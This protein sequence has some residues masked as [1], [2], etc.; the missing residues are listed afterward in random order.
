MGG[1]QEVKDIRR[2]ER[3]SYSKPIYFATENRIFGGVTQNISPAGVF[4][5][6]NDN[7][8]AGQIVILGIPSKKKKT[9]VKGKVVWSNLEG[10]GVK[11]LGSKKK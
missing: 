3:K 4:I 9:K 10:F 8:A 7:L 6:A 1:I 5:K 11:F 2:H